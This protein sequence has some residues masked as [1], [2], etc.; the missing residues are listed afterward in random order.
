MYRKV[1]VFA[2]VLLASFSLVGCQ[3]KTSNLTVTTTAVATTK[4]PDTSALEQLNNSLASPSA[5][6]SKTS[7]VGSGQEFIIDSAMID[8][9]F[10]ENYQIAL[11]DA[12]KSLKSGVRYCGAKIS[13]YGA[14]LTES[15]KQ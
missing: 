6:G 15:N 12:Q 4:S 7:T 14:S 3:K 2:S 5:T 11:E 10:R 9:L 1:F 8:S 13:F